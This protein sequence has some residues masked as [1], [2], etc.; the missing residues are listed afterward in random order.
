[1]NLRRIAVVVVVV[2]IA[3]TGIPAAALTQETIATTDHTRTGIVAADSA[4]FAVST[5]DS[6]N[7]AA[8]STNPAVT[9]QGL[10]VTVTQINSRN[11]PDVQAYVSVQGPAGSAVSGLTASDFTVTEDGTVER[12]TSVQQLNSTG[13]PISTVLVIDRSGSMDGSKMTD[14]KVAA[15]EFV[16][17]YGPGDEGEIV[18]FAYSARIDERWTRNTTDLTEAIGQIYSNGG[19]ALYDATYLG[20]EEAD[21][22]SGRSA[23]IVLTDGQNS[24]GIYRTPDA[25]IALAQERGISIYTIGLGSNV[26]DDQLERMSNETGG[27]YYFA[28]SSENLTEIYN[29]IRQQITSE[30]L[31]TYSTHN[32]AADGTN[33][34]VSVT[35]TDGTNSGTDDRTYKAPESTPPVAD[36]TM[37]TNNL[38]VTVDAA[39]AFDEDG[40]IVAYE[41]DFDNDGLVDATGET[42]TYAYATAGTHIMR[43]TVTDND[44]VSN[45]VT[46][47]VTL[48]VGPPVANEPPEAAFTWAP[49]NPDP[50]EVVTF[51]ASASADADGQIWK[52]GWTWD[53]GTVTDSRVDT[54]THSFDNPGIY[55]VTLRVVDDNN[56]NTTI[57]QTIVVGDVDTP[58]A[59]A[60]ATQTA[61]A[62]PAVT[63]TA[64]PD[65]GTSTTETPPTADTPTD[66]DDGTMPITDGGE[67]DGWLFCLLG[68]A[69]LGALLLINLGM[70][71]ARIL[72]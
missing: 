55:Q 34:T 19:T 45:Y 13:T 32:P 57:T 17:N 11:F 46:R 62:T 21:T 41:W 29:S 64:T 54:V 33:R 30:Y 24:D 16:S 68:W 70:L 37:A 9:A 28:P 48:R 8:D 63:Q 18:S 6:T 25:A 56:E 10:D 71:I 20:V 72:R 43:L 53:D 27:E 36:F 47:I 22:R 52:W 7:P 2:M 44:G 35:V 42:A 26:E 66:A 23:V 14:A 51:D 49:Q 12:L 58:T 67:D 4:N 69:L 3:A 39:T 60:T 1:M 31:L 65:D 40:V 50:G 38:S 61:T 15:T 59:T 5:A